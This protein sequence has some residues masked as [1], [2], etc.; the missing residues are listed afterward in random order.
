[1]NSSKL[2]FSGFPDHDVYNITAPFLWNKKKVIAGR[3]ERREQELSEIVLFDEFE[4]VWRPVKQAP[5]FPG[6]QDPCITKIDNR[7]IL[8]GVRF[9]LRI[10]NNE[11]CWQMEFF[12]EEENGKFEKILTGPPKMKDVR[13]LELPDGRI[14]CLTRPQGQKGGRGKIGFCLVDSLN[15]LS[16]ELIEN[17]T[18]LDLCPEEKWV[19]ANEAHLLRNG[20]VGVLGHIAEFCQKG[21]RHYFSMAFSID[22]KLGTSTKPEIIAKRKDFPKGETKRPDLIDV[23]FSGGIRRLGNGRSRLYAGLSDAEAGFLDLPDPFDKFE[24]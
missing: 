11:K 7:L 14:L 17:A 22:L 8:G 13:F 10:G 6:L 9:P 21:D 16:H 2:T 5:T 3:V 18:L 24:S 1:M 19:G 12:R 20:K 15:Q 23:I 4:G